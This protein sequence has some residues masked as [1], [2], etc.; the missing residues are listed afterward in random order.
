MKLG[1]SA[2]LDMISVMKLD[3]RKTGKLRALLENHPAALRF[4][5]KTIVI[6]NVA[7]IFF[8]SVSCIK[9]RNEKP[10]RLERR[11]FNL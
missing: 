7:L 3:I 1:N 11:K 6:S 2:S 10:P 5:K 8:V 9:A 4:N